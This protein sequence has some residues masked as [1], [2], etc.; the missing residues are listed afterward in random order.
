MV[1]LH[2]QGVV[3]LT[4]TDIFFNTNN[5]E[6]EI[7][8]DIPPMYYYSPFIKIDLCIIQLHI[9]NWKEC[10]IK[11]PIKLH[12]SRLRKL[13]YALL[14]EMLF[15]NQVPKKITLVKSLT[16]QNNWKYTSR[17]YLKS[18]LYLTSHARVP[19]T[20]FFVKNKLNCQAPTWN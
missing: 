11:I 2:Y 10:I 18:Q 3:T 12:A 7:Y 5:C 17:K 9:L 1:K 8:Q 20:Q 16:V 6:G 14:S 15:E 4:D 13:K 19:E